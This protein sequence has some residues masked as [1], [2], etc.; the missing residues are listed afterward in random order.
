M[1]RL[2]SYCIVF[3]LMIRR[4]PRSTLSSSSAASDVYKRQVVISTSLPGSGLDCYLVEGGDRRCPCCWLGHVMLERLTLAD[5]LAGL[6]SSRLGVRSCSLGCLLFCCFVQRNAYSDT[7]NGS[8]MYT[9]ITIRYHKDW[10][11]QWGNLGRFVLLMLLLLDMGLSLIH[12][13]DPTRLLS[14]SYAVF[15]LKKKK[16]KINHK[17][18]VL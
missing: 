5:W 1:H 11:N 15:C 14:I 7:D 8:V 18:V 17:D 13:S 16:K 10:G 4:P 3:F 12:I 6:L 9:I 2:L